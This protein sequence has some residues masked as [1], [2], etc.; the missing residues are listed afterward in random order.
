MSKNSFEIRLD[1]ICVLRETVYGRV[2]S[3]RVGDES[4]R[5]LQIKNRDPRMCDLRQTEQIQT[6]IGLYGATKALTEI[7]LEG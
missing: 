5:N 2:G 3:G 1:K 6:N 4:I 7:R